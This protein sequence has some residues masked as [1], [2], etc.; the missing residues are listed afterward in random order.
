M[1]SFVLLCSLA[2]VD[3]RYFWHLQ[4]DRKNNNNHDWKLPRRV[5]VSLACV[6][7]YIFF[8]PS[9]SSK[10][11]I[12]LSLAVAL[13]FFLFSIKRYLFPGIRVI[14]ILL[15][16]GVGDTVARYCLL[17]TRSAKSNFD[18]TSEVHSFLFASSFCI[19]YS[20]SLSHFFSSVTR[21]VKYSHTWPS[22]NP[23]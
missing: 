11:R 14:F 4:V 13:S 7:F 18:C 15:W 3:E 2:H 20:L 22:W 9:S 19:S 21:R 23:K 8:A 12:C 5:T 16:L 10:P 17:D 6:S 1:G